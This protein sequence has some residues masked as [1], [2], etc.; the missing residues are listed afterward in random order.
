MTIGY[1]GTDG[2]IDDDGWKTWKTADLAALRAKHLPAILEM[3]KQMMNEDGTA[4]CEASL[5]SYV[6]ALRYAAG[7]QLELLNFCY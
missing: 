7:E 3:H 1:L 6:E 5:T 2:M 4:V